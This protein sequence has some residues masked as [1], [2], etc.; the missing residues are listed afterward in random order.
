MNILGNIVFI[1]IIC[2]VIILLC[3]I[4]CS[5]RGFLRET[6]AMAGLVLGIIAAICFYKRIA[7]VIR[8]RFM[9]DAQA[10]PEILGFSVIFVSVCMLSALLG[11]LLRETLAGL[12]LGTAD[13]VMGAVF[14]LIEGLALVALLLFV[15]SVQS[16]FDKAAILEGSFFAQHILPM[17][18]ALPQMQ[19]GCG[20]A[21]WPGVSGTEWPAERGV[22]GADESVWHRF[23]PSV[24]SE[25]QCQMSGQKV[26]GTSGKIFPRGDANLCLKQ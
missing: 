10:L 14:G 23:P 15:I 20:A 9:P 18:R 7:A 25:A 3:V 8:G 2:A 19:L 22:R 17:L 6:L 21:L 12:Y 26:S 4:R 24:V 16:I 5:L 1:D 13:R 11:A